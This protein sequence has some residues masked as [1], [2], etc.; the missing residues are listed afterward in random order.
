MVLTRT[1]ARA[2]TEPTMGWFDG[3]WVIHILALWVIS[4]CV[5]APVRRPGHWAP[6]T[7]VRFPGQE[8]AAV[9]TVSSHQKQIGS[10]VSPIDDSLTGL[11]EAASVAWVSVISCFTKTTHRCRRRT[12]TRT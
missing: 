9:S 10:L 11:P 5:G 3:F 7:L 8:P 2:V 6:P 12:L 4:L 1:H